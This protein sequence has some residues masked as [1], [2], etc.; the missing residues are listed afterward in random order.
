MTEV[1]I[2]Q[3]EELHVSIIWKED[4]QWKNYILRAESRK[5]IIVKAMVILC[6]YTLLDQEIGE[7]GGIE[8]QKQ[9]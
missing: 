3:A 2:V 1:S 7:S 4:I 8:R 9:S 6:Y 5:R